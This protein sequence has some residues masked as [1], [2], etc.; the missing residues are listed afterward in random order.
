MSDLTAGL[1]ETRAGRSLSRRKDRMALPRKSALTALMA[2]VAMAFVG[3]AFAEATEPTALCTEDPGTGL[4]EVCPAT[5]LI[6]HV[7]EATLSTN[8]AVLKNSFLAT[9]CDV[10]FLGDV[11]N[12]SPKLY[13]AEAGEKLLISGTFTYTNCNNSC[14][15]KEEN[16]P[17]HIKVLKTGHELAEVT[18]EYLVHIICGTSLDCS[19]NGTN[20]NGH[21]LGSLL[22]SELNG[23]VTL[24]SQVLT[25]EAGGFLCPKTTELTIQITP[26]TVLTYITE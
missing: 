25:K 3:T 20:L 11:L 10:L 16:G 14:A 8:Q 22:S 19:Y 12:K 4:H 2:L 26:L 13:L 9:K 17:A 7:H 21:G 18:L 24:T 23:D 6:S 5:K 15:P 1:G